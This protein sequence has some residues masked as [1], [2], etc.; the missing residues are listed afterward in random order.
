MKDSSTLYAD[1]VQRESL[2]IETVK[3][4][5]F[6]LLADAPEFDIKEIAHAISMQCR[7]TGHCARF[8]SVAEHSVLVAHIM[9][10]FEL[11]NPFEGL[12]HDAQEAYLSDIASPWKVL[13]PDYKRIEA[14]LELK[15]RKF[16]GLSD[17]ISDGCKTADWVALFVEAAYL[18]PSKAADW[19][20]PPGVAELV[21]EFHKREP[22]VELGS[23]PR[24][25]HDMFLAEF[26]RMTAKPEGEVTQ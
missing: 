19:P 23:A 14:G 4:R 13:L 18:I 25:A 26:N 21:A 16:Y 9:Q 1:Q 7:Y 11:G 22:V 12:M 8:Y 20:S 24:Y 3:G 6:Y 15:L 5:K 17:K 2:Y 10:M